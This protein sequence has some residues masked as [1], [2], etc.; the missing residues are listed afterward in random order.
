MQKELEYFVEAGF[1]ML[2]RRKNRHFYVVFQDNKQKY[3]IL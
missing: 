1:R 2:K 3:D